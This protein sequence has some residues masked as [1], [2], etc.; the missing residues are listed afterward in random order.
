MA[1]LT[2]VGVRL[3]VN[4]SVPGYH[5]RSGT[6]LL[7]RVL[8]TYSVPAAALIGTARILQPIEM[9]RARPFERP[10]DQKGVAAGA[11]AC[12][13][14]AILVIFVWINLA[15]ADLFAEGP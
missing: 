13:V 5:S 2:A 11:V 8:Y 7:N 14:A 3:I 12:A 9:E 6:P 10:P 4:P 15:I 1:L